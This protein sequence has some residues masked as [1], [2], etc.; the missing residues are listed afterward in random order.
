[1][2][3]QQRCNSAATAGEPRL[4][5]A[6][7][8]ELLQQLQWKRTTSSSSTPPPH[9]LLHLY[10]QRRRRTLASAYRLDEAETTPSC[11]WGMTMLSSLLLLRQRM[12]LLRQRMPLLDEAEKPRSMLSFLLESKQVLLLLL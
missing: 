8:D 5:E 9:I 2:R 11:L 6:A 10:I 7:A 3:L 4:Q 12:P 1:M